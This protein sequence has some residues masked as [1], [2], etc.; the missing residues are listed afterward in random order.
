MSAKF[1]LKL[2]TSQLMSP[3]ALQRKVDLQ[4][5]QNGQVILA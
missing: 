3:A 5:G 1:D 4:W 2:H